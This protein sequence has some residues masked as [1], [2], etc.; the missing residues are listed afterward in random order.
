[1]TSEPGEVESL[2]SHLPFLYL[3]RGFHKDS[4]GHGKYRGGVGM[5]YAVKIHA[6]PNAALGTWGFGSKI[7]LSQGLYGGYGVPAL[8][9]IAISDSN[10]DDML[11]RSD[12]NIPGSAEAL[13]KEQAIKGHYR[14]RGYPC[15]AEPTR[16]G[17]LVAGGTGGGGGYGDPIERDPSL[18][19]M[20]L[21][22]EAIS[23]WAARNV[24]KVVYDEKRLAVDE[25]K[26]KSLREQERKDRKARGKKYAQFEKEWLKKRPNEETLEFYGTWPETK[27][28]SFSYF[29]DWPGVSGNE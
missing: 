7:T 23:H 28:E 18:V 17:D 1:M 13:Y 10:L 11:S 20:D 26:T 22:K 12:V 15:V 29:G 3:Y 6:V 24:Y 27:Y 25:E 2:E 21:E 16:E 9:F 14:L 5:D 4:C 8:P 19:M